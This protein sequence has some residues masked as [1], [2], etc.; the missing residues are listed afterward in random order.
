MTAPLLVGFQ[1]FGG[2]Q[3]AGGINYLAGLLEALGRL[4][5][6]PVAPVLFVEPNADEEAVARV[7][8]HLARPPVRLGSRRFVRLQRGARLAS[9]LALG[10]DPIAARALRDSGVKVLFHHMVWY[11]P[12]VGVPTIAW[13]PDFQHRRL[14]EMFG[15]AARTRREFGYRLLTRHADAIVVSSTDALRDCEQFFPASRGRVAVLRFGVRVPEGVAEE[16]PDATR[17]RYE[18]PERYLFFPGQMWRHKN[19]L[20]LVAAVRELR[21][22]GREIVVACSGSLED[23]RDSGHPRSVIDAIAHDGLREC[24]RIL[25]HIPYRDMVQLMRGSVAMVNPSFAEGWST[26]VEEAKALAV[27]LVLSNLPVHREQAGDGA[28][29]FDPASAKA[30]ADALWDSWTVGVPGGATAAAERSAAGAAEGRWL[31]FARDFSALARSVAR[32]PG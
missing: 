26:T 25:G 30:M 1:L 21:A 10:R 17:A 12:R 31:Q 6:Q 23:Y 15:W 11:G 7:V 2:R 19:H 18:L 5:D 9:A 13:L 14:P 8:P 27:P 20:G 24:V 16:P 3:W 28:R 29:F 4:P 32:D 22:R